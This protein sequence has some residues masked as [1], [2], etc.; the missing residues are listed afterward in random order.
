MNNHQITRIAS[1]ALMIVGVILLLLTFIQGDSA[2]G[3]FIQWGYLC[4]GIAT[5]AAI[6]FSL[7]NLFKDSTKARNTLIG[8]GALLVVFVIAYLMS[9]G[10]DYASFKGFDITEGTSRLVSTGLNAFY[11]FFI[12]AVV[13]ILYTEA[14]KIL[15]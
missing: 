6:V 2:V 4:F 1:F 5:V 14:N 3:F 15:K 13:S 12:L 7:L 8:I 9:S 11:I 10:A